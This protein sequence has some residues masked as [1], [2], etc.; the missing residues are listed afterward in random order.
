MSRAGVAHR[1]RY[2][3]CMHMKIGDVVKGI[4]AIDWNTLWS[5]TIGAL[6]AGLVA[7]GVA[8]YVVNRS[9]RNAS[10]DVL[11]TMHENDRLARQ[12]RADA[13]VAL[14]RQLAEQR[15]LASLERQIAARTRIVDLL[16]EF[17]EA[18]ARDASIDY[19]Q[20]DRKIAMAIAS[21]RINLNPV[22]DRKMRSELSAWGGLFH[23]IED[24]RGIN[25]PA[26]HGRGILNRVIVDLQ[27]AA[28]NYR[29]PLPEGAWTPENTAEFLREARMIGEEFYTARE[30][31]FDRLFERKPH[32]GKG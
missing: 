32:R 19:A 15:E 3:H 13:Q 20:L 22:D 26:D 25:D 9:T 29:D 31:H 2:G 27:K 4:G 24:A 18:T 1:F 23:E 7:A 21:W 17:S 6:I 12:A 8:L 5:G 28:L 14:D 10:L 30:H 16:S 11:K